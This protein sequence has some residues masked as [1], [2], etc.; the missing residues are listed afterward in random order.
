MRKF[1]KIAIKC[2]SI[3]GALSIGAGVVGQ[4]FIQSKEKGIS[5][6]AQSNLVKTDALIDTNIENYFDESVVQKLPE[7]VT[8]NEDI[9]VIVS[10]HEDSLMDGFK[11]QSIMKTVSDYATTRQA[12]TLASQIARK[13]TAWINR[14]N[15]SGISYKLGEKYDTVINGFEIIIK[16]KDFEEVNKFFAY[17]ATLIVGDVYETAVAE[18][19]HNYVDVYESGIFDTSTSTY[20][21]DG[22]VVAVLDTGL[23]YTHTAFSVENFTTENEAF[24][25]SNV[26]EKV[27]ATVAAQFTEGLT[28]MDVYV[29]KKVPFAYDYADKDPDVLPINSDHGTHVAG[30]IAGNDDEITGVAPNAQLAIMKVFSDE[31]QGAKDSW[32]LAALEDCVIL[33]VDVINMSLGAGCGFTREVDK[34]NKNIVYDKIREAGISL[35]AAAGNDYSA[36]LGSTKN[37]NNP[38]TSNPDSGPVGAPAT[39]KASLAV[40]SIDGVKTPY[41]RCDGD[42]FYFKEATAADAKPRHFVD[43]ILEPLGVDSYD[44]EYVTI[45]GLGRSADYPEDKEFYSG[46]IVLVK[47]GQTTFEDKVRVAIVEKGAAGIIICV[48]HLSTAVATV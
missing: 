10:L 42:M 46:K 16:A 22:V 31:K 39:Y 28:G 30:I 2:M 7:T 19:I 26:S 48:K 27:G 25:L 47:R 36:T 29:N 32:I 1:R 12:K 4:S 37:G 9:S 20:Q 14:L 6:S 45:P 3:V 24:T 21:G 11:E 41:L 23:D 8:S 5:A 38:L 18:P 34:E 35:I 33:G 17:D 44:F 40:A 13:Q 15:N 43:E